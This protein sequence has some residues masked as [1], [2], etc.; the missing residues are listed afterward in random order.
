MDITS[1]HQRYLAATPWAS[2]DAL[3]LTHFLESA[4]DLADAYVDLGDRDDDQLHMGVFTAS[5]F[6]FIVDHADNTL[7]AL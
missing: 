4:S 5:E 6:D 1:L 2:G 7:P 3:S